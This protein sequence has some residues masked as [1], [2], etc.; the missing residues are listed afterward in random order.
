MQVIYI[1]AKKGWN[2]ANYEA[3]VDTQ[4][5]MALSNSKPM[6]ARG[7]MCY[8]LNHVSSKKIG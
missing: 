6:K 7:G 3:H 5:E 1:K 8:G 2:Q 4:Q